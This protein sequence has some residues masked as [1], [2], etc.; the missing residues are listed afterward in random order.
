M[1]TRALDRLAK[2][3][4]LIN[5]ALEVDADGTVDLYELP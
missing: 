5:R 4:E 3:P 1:F 2:L